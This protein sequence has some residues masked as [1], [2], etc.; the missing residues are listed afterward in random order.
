MEILI[1]GA[2][3]VGYRLAKTLSLKN[4]VYIID[5][6]REALSHLLETID[7]L[8]IYGDI[9]DPDTYRELREREFHIFIAVTDSDEANILSTLIATD[10]IQI[11]KKIIRLRNPYFAKSSLAT[12]LAITEAVFPFIATADS[13]RLLL[14]FPLA[15]NVK[16]IPFS[17]Y[18]LLSVQASAPLIERY[19][20]IRSSQVVAVAFEREKELHL[21]SGEVREG[22][23]IYLFGS[24]SALKTISTRLNSRPFSSIKRV[25]LFGGDPV[26]LE[27]A[28]RLLARGIQLKLIEEDPERCRKAHEL[29]QGRATVINSKYSQHTIFQEE[30]LH[31]ADMVIATSSNDEENIIKCLEAKEYGIGRTIAI[32]NNHEYYDLM[33]K[34]SIVPIR[35][36]KMSAYYQILEKIASSKV[37]SEKHYCGGRGSLFVRKVFPDS[38]LIG[39]RVKPPKFEA[40]LLI[41]REGRIEEPSLPLRE[42]DLILIFTR[43][44]YEEEAQEWIYNL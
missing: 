21:P 17:N 2:G 31:H 6:N 36:P 3:Q 4:N 15:N 25:A 42:G 27:I 5:K 43:S 35:G 32:N 38:P 37:I 1:A 28:Q 33:H 16:E 9:E 8:T 40:L 41:V 19:E 39:R 29:L 20:E 30:S 44:D 23:L 18:L 14:D 10:A 12:R 7:I 24:P 22:D 34:L 11:G 13:F 26:A